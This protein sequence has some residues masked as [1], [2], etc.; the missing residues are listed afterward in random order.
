MIGKVRLAI[1]IS[2]RGSNMQAI[3]DAA[4]TESD[5]PAEPALVLSNR[6]GAPG[7]LTARRAGIA[8]IAI[9][10]KAFGNDREAFE[11][12]IDAALRDANTELVALAGFMRIL[13]PWFVGRWKGRLINIHPSLLPKYKGLNTHQRAIEAGD[14]HGGA[15]AHWVSEDVD[16]GAVISQIRVPIAPGETPETLEE[17]VLA[18][19][20]V[21]YPKAVR[22]ACEKLLSQRKTG[23]PHP[24]SPRKK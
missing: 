22:Q 12:H 16:G 10:H 17:K 15:S 7:L 11:R 23:S 8:T 3:L 21:L 2:G 18:A 9:D 4:S 20:H 19:E 1:L 13:T 14:S 24:A 5:Y 6:P